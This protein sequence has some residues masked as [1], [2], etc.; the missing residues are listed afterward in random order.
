MIEC[1]APPRLVTPSISIVSEPAPSIRAPISVKSAAR[2]TAAGGRQEKL[3]TLLEIGRRTGISYPTLLRYVKLYSD[4][5]PHVGQ[6]RRRRYPVAA[7]KEFR[8]LRRSSKRGPRAKSRGASSG[9][10]RRGTASDN[11]LKARIRELEKA[12]RQVT[13]QLDEI[14]RLLKKPMRITVRSD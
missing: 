11:A 4:E 3:L 10:A 7:V 14:V 6:G 13:R 5:I 1:S 12:Q 2:S 8:R 9:A